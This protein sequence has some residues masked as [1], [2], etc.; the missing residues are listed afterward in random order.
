MV[1]NGET[2]VYLKTDAGVFRMA[3]TESVLFLEEGDRISVSYA[4]KN[5]SADGVTE[6][7]AVKKLP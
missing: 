1:Q 5:P 3:F 4:Q 6:A 2:S 7:Y